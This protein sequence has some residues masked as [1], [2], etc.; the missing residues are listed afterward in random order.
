MPVTIMSTLHDLIQMSPQPYE[1]RIILL[2]IV[3]I[4][5]LR[6]RGVGSEE[7]GKEM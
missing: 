2:P 4:R 3:Q 6:V 5:K 7:K 1:V